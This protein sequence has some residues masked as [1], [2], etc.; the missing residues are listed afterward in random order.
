MELTQVPCRA[1]PCQLLFSFQTAPQIKSLMKTRAT[2]AAQKLFLD[3]S[4]WSRDWMMKCDE[5]CDKGDKGRARQR[6]SQLG[7]LNLGFH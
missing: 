7:K 6:E 5:M 2:P 3:R 1:V 4:V